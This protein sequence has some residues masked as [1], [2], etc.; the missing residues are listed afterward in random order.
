M[1][2]HSLFAKNKESRSIGSD[3]F[4]LCPFR[5]ELVLVQLPVTWAA[6][7]VSR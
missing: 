3:D 4:L 7:Y 5:R 1:D 6:M 2:C